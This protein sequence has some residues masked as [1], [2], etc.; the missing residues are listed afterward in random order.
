MKDI[1]SSL[2]LV[3]VDHYE[4]F[5]YEYKMCCFHKH[6]RILQSHIYMN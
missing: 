6:L 1:I 3:E 4:L 2:L 5:F